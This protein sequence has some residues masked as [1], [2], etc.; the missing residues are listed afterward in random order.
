MWLKKST[1]VVSK[2][3]SIMGLENTPIL[4]D[5]FMKVIGSLAKNKVKEFFS[6]QILSQECQKDLKDYLKMM[7]W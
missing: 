1:K 4:M 2:M 7:K 6:I 5:H 3:I